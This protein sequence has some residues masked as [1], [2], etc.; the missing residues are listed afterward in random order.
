MRYIRPHARWRQRTARVKLWEAG[1]TS[2]RWWKDGQEATVEGRGREGGGVGG[3]ADHLFGVCV[4][5]VSKDRAEA[6]TKPLRCTGEEHGE[7]LSA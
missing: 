2:V 5:A 1:L 3:S 4:C 6:A 7:A